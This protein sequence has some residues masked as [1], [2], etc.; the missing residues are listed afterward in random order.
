MNISFIT[1]LPIDKA[2][3]VAVDIG[4]AI[5]LNPVRD[6]VIELDFVAII[7]KVSNDF[8]TEVFVLYFFYV[9]FELLFYS[10]QY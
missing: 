7:T 8:I 4:I 9:C 3:A 10:L 5:K 1:S 6:S 2:H